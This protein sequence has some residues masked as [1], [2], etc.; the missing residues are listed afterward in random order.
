MKI[1][2]ERRESVYL[3]RLGHVKLL[4][5][6]A[7]LSNVFGTRT[8]VDG[9]NILEGSVIGIFRQQITF[10]ILQI[11]FTFSLRFFRKLMLGS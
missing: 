2:Y 5:A 11:A 4:G 3:L 9:S 10:D 8:G 1:K 6:S 7:S